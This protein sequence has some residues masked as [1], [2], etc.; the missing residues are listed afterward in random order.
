MA[1]QTESW[2]R[3]RY[4]E[5]DQMGVVYHANYLVWFEI[6]RTDHMRRCGIEYR[7]LEERGYYL[8]VVEVHCRYLRPARYDQCCRIRTRV[9]WYNGLRLRFAYVVSGE[10]GTPLAEGWSEHVFVTRDGGPVRPSRFDPELDRRI[11]ELAEP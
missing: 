6:G 2:V 10:D 4:Q 9:E 3:V 1:E 11:R 7:R 8:P 5:T